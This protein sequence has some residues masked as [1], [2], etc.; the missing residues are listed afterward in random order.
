MDN[1]L[2]LIGID[3]YNKFTGEGKLLTTCVKDVQDFKFVL[4]EK[5]FFEKENVIELVNA[6][7]TNINIQN[8]LENYSTILNDES[9][10]VIYFSG[11]GGLRTST[12]RGYWIPSD[13]NETDYSNWIG[14]ETILNLISK[15][16]AKH[17]VV[18]SDC[19]FATSLLLT[20][21]SKSM[22]NDLDLYTSRWALTSGREIT[23]CGGKGENSF[24]G[25]TLINYLSQTKKDVRFGSLVEAVKSAFETNIL[26]KPQG[27]PLMDKRHQGGEFVFKIRDAK[28]LNNQRLKGYKLFKKIIDRYT[29]SNKIEELEV[30]ESK[31]NKIGYH[32]IREE[33]KIKKTVT[34]YLYLYEGIIQTRTL[35]HLREKHAYIF[36]GNTIIFL[37]KEV[38][39][40]NFEARKKNIG[41]LFSPLNIFYIDEF[42]ADLCSRYIE[43]DDEKY[44]NIKNFIE[45]DYKGAN[46]NIRDWYKEPDNPILV[47]KGTAGIGKTTFAKFISDDYAKSDNRNVLFVD[48]HE[49]LEE[50]NKQYR[51][52][53]K[54]DLYDLY[55][56]SIVSSEFALD[57]DLFSLSMDAGN[58]LL[59]IDGLEE[60]ISRSSYFDI[61]YFFNSIIS[62]NSGLGNTKIVITSRTFFWD[63]SN[64]IDESI[65]SVELEPFDDKR[66]D[67]FF[68]KSFIIE[69]NKAKKAI[70]ISEEFSLPDD[71]GTPYYH[72]FVLD[73]IKEI[74]ESDQEVLFSDSTVESKWLRSENKIDYIIYRI[75]EREEKRVMQVKV[76]SQIEI[77]NHLAVYEKGVINE[78]ELKEFVKSTLHLVEID[79]NIIN[80]LK[81]HPFL[82]YNKSKKLFTFRY[83]FFE[84]YFISLFIRR[85]LDINNENE[86]DSNLI[87][88]FSQKLNHGSDTIAHLLLNLEDWTE[89]NIMK[90][91]DLIEQICEEE[92]NDKKIRQKS[93]SGLFNLALSANIHF[94]S[95]SRS[96]NTKLLKDLFSSSHGSNL[97]NIHLININSL[98]SKIRF[99][100]SN[101]TI[102]NSVFDNYNLFWECNGNESTYFFNCSLAR[103]GVN[104][105][106]TKIPKV[107]F[108]NCTVEDGS[109]EEAYS[110]DEEILV[111]SIKKAKI[112]FEG[113]ARIF[114]KHGKFKKISEWIVEDPLNYGK[115]VSYGVSSKKLI[116]ELVNNGVLIREKDLKYGDIKI[117]INVESKEDVLKFITEGKQTED[118]IDVVELIAKLMK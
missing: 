71:E 10:L 97:E 48:S 115:I 11:H 28:Q 108:V 13:A 107:N 14:N 19:C 61:D 50:L 76:D 117:S 99:D 49:I 105:K 20:N 102:S 88:L 96:Q 46:I 66:R 82:K 57:A 3:R 43:D 103:L 33:D 114:Y 27:Y 62:S 56:A 104:K 23:Y 79:D 100:F 111:N 70:K 73:I 109:L 64:I 85:L 80:S 29:S 118:M 65:Q 36:R 95:N 30:Y 81:S 31:T 59:I 54:L 7:A 116:T 84:N 60:I 113:F 93:I 110:V 25:E 52:G 42:I 2:L 9:N 87:K 40:T 89:D 69:P 8:E 44:L 90:I 35:E 24:F 101:L 72:P 77:F 21:P 75:S 47:V 86:I 38:N 106:S 5:F 94:T 34:H 39:Q 12:D 67:R 22:K 51:L 53:K 92:F 1:H 18:L 55:K 78:N 98:E 91:R 6:Q 112:L 4:L 15:I 41:S 26:Q 45:P 16:N 74:V 68:R 17:V 37:P 63:K 58:L 32:L 83:D